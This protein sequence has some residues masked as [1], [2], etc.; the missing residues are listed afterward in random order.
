MTMVATQSISVSVKE[1]FSSQEQTN[2]A[3]SSTLT[4]LSRATTGPRG[5]LNVRLEPVD[6][7]IQHGGASLRP[8]A[9]AKDDSLVL[10]GVVPGRYW[11]H[12]DSSHGYASSVASGGVDLMTEPLVVAN[13][14]AAPIEITMRD[15]T[16]QVEG[17]IEGA[18]ASSAGGQRTTLAHVYCV[19]AADSPGRFAEAAA[20]ADGTFT[21]LNL[22]PGVYR[23]LA[24]QHSQLSLEFRNP[25]VMRAYET[26]GPV[27]HLTSGGKE[28][29]TVPLISKGE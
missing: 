2:D 6:D 29:V 15:D 10:E 22:P 12:I 21:F 14:S 16:A 7:F 11:V 13:G 19:P 17:T 18:D 23:V 25:E 3:K 27:V 4:R 1:E 9:N 26:S 28:H 20:S 8:A 5:Y 24:F